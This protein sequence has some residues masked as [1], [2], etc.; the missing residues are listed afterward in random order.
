MAIKTQGNASFKLQV[1]AT[2]PAPDPVY[3]LFRLTET[4]QGRQVNLT[5][6]LATKPRGSAHPL[7]ASMRV[8]D[9]DIRR[10][11]AGW[12]DV[13]FRY[14]GMDGGPTGPVTAKRGSLPKTGSVTGKMVRRFERE[15]SAGSGVLGSSSTWIQ[16]TQ[17]IDAEQT[18]SYRTPTITYRY[19]SSVVVKAPQLSATADMA[20]LEPA[21]KV[22]SQR[23]TGQ[24]WVTRDGILT[25]SNLTG[26]NIRNMTQWFEGSTG[27]TGG[28]PTVVAGDF[29]C[30]PVGASG[31]NE[32][33]ET[34]E[35]QL[36]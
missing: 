9:Y 33:E 1:G 12:C 24:E 26:L 27:E 35:Y 4:W 6:F 20:G 22:E 23:I 8:V 2:G 15:V 29:S 11:E 31:W 25:A 3:Q 19:A 10:L 21:V 13:E 18:Y 32:V 7:Y 5:A 36:V 30:E 16:I 14:A 28:T 17:E 34:H